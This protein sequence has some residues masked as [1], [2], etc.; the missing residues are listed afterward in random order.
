MKQIFYILALI[1]FLATCV[2]NTK[3]SADTTSSD[4]LLD[5][6]ETS[7]QVVSRF[8]YKNILEVVNDTLW[9]IWVERK[10]SSASLSL[11]FYKNTLEVAYSTA[12]Y[13]F[14][15]YKIDGDKIVVYWDNNIDT[16]YNNIDIVKA[17]NKTDKKYIGKPF[18]ILELENDTT[19]KATY[20]LKE[21][22]R[23]I[24]NSSVEKRTFFPDKYVVVQDD[25]ILW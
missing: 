17:I 2:A 19:L 3:K 21:L 25:F 22:V 13:L 5:T 4:I 12:C 18:M 7:E 1:F 20:I 16:K 24:N 11:H 10:D 6:I 9:S 14:Y 8:L 23:K 15:P